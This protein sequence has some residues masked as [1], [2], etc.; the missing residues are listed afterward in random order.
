VSEGNQVIH[1]EP[2]TADRRPP[3]VGPVRSSGSR[4]FALRVPE[5][6]GLFAFL[7]ALVV[8]FAIKSPDF[9]TWNNW[10][11]ILTVAAVTGIIAAPATLLLVAGHFDLSV[12]SGA[13]LCGVF[14]ATQFAQYD[15]VLAMLLTVLLGVIIGAINGFFVSVVGI[16]SLITT[17]GTL[18]AFRGLSQILADGQ[19]VMLS[20]FSWLGTAR[21]FLN[22]PVPV[23]LLIAVI[24]LFWLVMRYTVYGRTM[25]AIGSSEPAARLS[26]LR[27]NRAI[28]FGFVVSGLFVALSGMILTSQ[29]SAASPIAATSLELSVVTAVVLGGASLNGGRGSVIGTALGLLILGV[30]QNGLILQN[31]SSFW[32]QVA[33][34]ALLV[35][36]VS[37]DQINRR[38]TK[39]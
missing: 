36:A 9:L 2:A 7:I 16:N 21:P 27:P 32:Q 39:S 20:G 1:A 6:A 12:G 28:F 35:V 37:M 14:F 24:A 17:L 19:T 33:S 29:L 38:F 4:N 30:L 22:I 5:R 18:A 11:N 26:G 25:Y 10:V 3:D 34:G 23:L 8:F 31:V 13:A 15:P